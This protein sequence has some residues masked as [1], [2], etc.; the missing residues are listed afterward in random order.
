MKKG[1]QE[2]AVLISIRP[3]WCEMIISGEKTVEVRKTRPKIEPP[4]KCYI[5]CTHPN[6]PHEDFF[7]L[8]PGTIDATAFYG[9]GHIIGEFI[10]DDIKNIVQVGFPDRV[11][12]EVSKNGY[13]LPVDYPA[14]CLTERQLNDY[15]AGKQLYGWNIHVCMIYKQPIAYI[16]FCHI[17]GKKLIKHPPQNWC[18]VEELPR[19][20]D[21]K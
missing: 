19:A 13:P 2:T 15:G 10:C 5:Y 14:M 20:E 21:G 4:F 1:N 7:V 11:Y 16:E 3:E 9:G 18:Y 17:G 6:Y 12:S 8:N